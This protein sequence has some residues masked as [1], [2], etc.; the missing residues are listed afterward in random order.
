MVTKMAGP[1]NFLYQKKCV[2]LWSKGCQYCSGSLIKK[3]R[4]LDRKDNSLDYT[5]LTVEEMEAAMKAVLAF[6]LGK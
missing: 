3:R 6:R 5:V 4:G 1:E 2:G